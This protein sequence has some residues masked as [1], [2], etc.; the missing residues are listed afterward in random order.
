NGSNLRPYVLH[1][2]ML[3]SALQACIGLLIEPA[4][5][6]EP[7]V[8]FVLDEVSIVSELPAQ[9]WAWVRRRSV[10][11]RT[12]AVGKRTGASPVATEFD[13]DVCDDEG[14]VALCL[15]GLSLRALPPTDMPLG[16]AQGPTEQDVPAGGDLAENTLLGTT[17]EE[18]K[19]L[20]YVPQWDQIVLS[21]TT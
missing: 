14:R 2:A 6:Q 4:E 10:G 17:Q 13:I 19:P 21:Q 12:E 16:Q 8:P 9:G 15:R 20:L 7:P 1:P 18:D 3:D 11:T 5:H